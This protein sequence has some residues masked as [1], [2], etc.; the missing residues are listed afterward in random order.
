MTLTAPRLH[1]A[2]TSIM[3][4]AAM[5]VLTI[6]NV[7]D[8]LYAKLRTSAAERRRS[9]NS[10]VIECLRSALAARRPRQVEGFLDRARAA[11]ET[12]SRAGFTM[13]LAEADEARREGRA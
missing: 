3:L 5:P 6:R 13:S 8:D 9:I 10:E 4:S 2:V 7:P 12:L 1:S 11:R